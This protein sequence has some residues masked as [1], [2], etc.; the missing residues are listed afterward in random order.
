MA[1]FDAQHNFQI[2]KFVEIKTKFTNEMNDTCAFEA[3]HFISCVR[4]WIEVTLK[5][6]AYDN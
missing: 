1:I 3:A 2:L 4:H 6:F 5:A